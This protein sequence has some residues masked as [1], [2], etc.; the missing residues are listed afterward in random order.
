MKSS[1]AWQIRRSTGLQGSE[2]ET[3]QSPIKGIKTQDHNIVGE[4]TAQNNISPNNDVNAAVPTATT[5]LI[6]GDENNKLAFD[7]LSEH[8]SKIQEASSVV[9]GRVLDYREAL[10]S[11][12]AEYTRM[13]RRLATKLAD[14]DTNQ[15]QPER[16]H[17]DE[18]LT[19]SMM[20]LLP[21]VEKTVITISES[22]FI[23][24]RQTIYNNNSSSMSS[25]EEPNED[26]EPTADEEII[27]SR[28]AIDVDTPQPVPVKSV[29]TISEVHKRKNTK[30]VSAH[31][32]SD[33]QPDSQL[34]TEV[35]TS[36]GLAEILQRQHETNSA[37]GATDDNLSADYQDAISALPASMRELTRTAF[38]LRATRNAN[39]DNIGIDKCC[40][41]VLQHCSDEG[42][43]AKLRALKQGLE[44]HILYQNSLIAVVRN[45]LL[46]ESF[47][48]VSV[49][50]HAK[51]D[52]PDID[53]NKLCGKL[54]IKHIGKRHLDLSEVLGSMPS[55]PPVPTVEIMQNSELLSQDAAWRKTQNG[56]RNSPPLEAIA[57]PNRRRRHSANIKTDENQVS[58]YSVTGNRYAKL[59]SKWLCVFLEVH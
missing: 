21:K 5:T 30:F 54:S 58:E 14:H 2:F 16:K 39:I 35:E 32:N 33:A 52:L 19:T 11:I 48:N 6:S 18:N 42:Q 24:T 23:D 50:I 13:H 53:Y 25:D 29:D 34:H 8:L 17:S 44:T 40:E 55:P 41:G 51:N 56:G 31:N 45:A 38:A 47:I 15:N 9:V 28:N 20:D 46:S 12:F 49:N 22:R 1:V 27:S 36:S 10:S 4:V 57:P 43:L 3:Q 37:L 59:V 7:Q 26:G